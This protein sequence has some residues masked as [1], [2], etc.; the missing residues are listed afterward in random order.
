MP[1]SLV[2]MRRT[3]RSSVILSGPTSA[4]GYRAA[5]ASGGGAGTAR[6]RR[7]GSALWSWAFLLVRNL[8]APLILREPQDEREG[9]AAEGG[10]K[11]AGGDHGVLPRAAVIDYQI[12]LTEVTHPAHSNQSCEA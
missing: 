6:R 10:G 7:E 2:Q 11:G 5:P 12:T 3:L 4:P 8:V 1:A 9:T